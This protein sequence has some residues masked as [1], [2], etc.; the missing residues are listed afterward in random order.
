MA[1]LEY[2]RIQ[3]AV[4]GAAAVCLLAIEAL[5]QWFDAWWIYP[6]VLLVGVA[7]FTRAV[8]VKLESM[9]RTLK[10]QELRSERLFASTAVGMVLV[11]QG[12][13]ILRLNPAAERMTGYR[14]DELVGRSVCS[15]LFMPLPDGKPICFETCL[16]LAARGAP[17]GEMATMTLQSKHG[18][19]LS[20]AVC[21]TSLGEDEFSLVFW[22]ISERTRLE[23]ELARRR[24]QAESLYEVGRT[25][26]SMVDL[27]RNLERLLDKAREVM[28]AD[29]AG[30]ATLDDTT[31]DLQWQVVAGA[32]TRF[33]EAALP[34]R[35][36]VT[37]RVLAAGRPYVTQNLA[38]DVSANE[39]ASALVE[40]ESLRAALAIPLKVRDRHY[41]VLFVGHRRPARMS[42][43]DLLL[44]SNLGSH[45]SIAVEN[46]DLLSRMQHLAALEERQRLAREMHDSFGQILTMVT[47]R[48]H[49]MEGMVKQSQSEEL[50][51]E[52]I[53]L[54]SELKASH[55][56]VR[57]TIYALKDSGPALA[58]L[59]DR[60]AE[61]LKSF[62]RQSGIQTDM[63]GREAVPAHLPERV[64]SQITRVIQEALT[65]VR[66]HSGAERVLLE[67]YRNGSQLVVVVRDNGCGFEAKKAAGPDEYHFGLGIMRE[68]VESIGGMLEIESEI[69][70][71]TQVRIIVPAFDGGGNDHVI[72][73]GLAGR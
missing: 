23:R 21:V 13:R 56:D 33:A 61:H 70:H 55:Q 22:D 24:R 64:E 1:G 44:L 73:Q 40:S 68:R 65:N 48:L 41:G 42:D 20:V 18:R 59:W 26:A 3:W 29:L 50:L 30:W 32:R 37:G 36:T 72:A 51:H 8:F 57:R 46:N 69:G 43:E 34:L 15:D 45:L 52:I 63:V 11:G 4:L 47:M 31:C 6:P 5:R 2:H 58:P 38:T 25:M 66:N 49:L 71:G 53:D 39:T 7:I 16:G 19:H 27:D 54:R 9:N 62:S 17:T 14:S 60:W 10:T 28:D 35:D 67:A 12:C